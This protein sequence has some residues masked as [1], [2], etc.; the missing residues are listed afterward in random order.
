[1]NVDR[2]RFHG[3]WNY[4]IR[5]RRTARAKYF[6][7]AFDVAWVILNPEFGTLGPASRSPMSDRAQENR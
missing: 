6:P 1:M 4:V 2:N 3:D 5:P 7:S